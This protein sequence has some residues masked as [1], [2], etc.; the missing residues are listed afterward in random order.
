MIKTVKTTY[1]NA[2]RT[3]STRQIASKLPLNKTDLSPRLSNTSNQLLDSNN[4]R[5]SI[6]PNQELDTRDKK[7]VLAQM[8]Q[9]ISTQHSAITSKPKEPPIVLRNINNFLFATLSSHFITA[10]LLK[11]SDLNSIRIQNYVKSYF[12]ATE[13]NS[14]P[15]QFT[16]DNQDVSFMYEN[17]LLIKNFYLFGVCDGH[18]KNGKL[19]ADAVS[20]LFP[21]NL[22]YLIIDNNLIKRNENL[23]EIVISLFKMEE[24]SEVKD[25]NLLKYFFMKLDIDFD[26]ISFVKQALHLIRNEIVEAI[27]RTNEDC[28]TRK[29][30]DA[31]L[32]GCTLCS[33]FIYGKMLYAANVGDSRAVL[34]THIYDKNRWIT[35]ELTFD[36]KPDNIMEAK[37]IALSGGRIAQT[38][39]EIGI[40]GGPFRVWLK[41]SDSTTPGLAISR[42]IGDYQAKTIGVTYEPSIYEYQLDK[43]DKIIIIATDGLWE[44]MKNEQ[45]I[46]ICGAFYENKKRAEDASYQLIQKAKEDKIKRNKPYDDITCVVIFL[47]VKD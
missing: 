11:K 3:S 9:Q 16:S 36:H 44:N 24:K 17:F 1:P 4:K 47:D 13:K 25:I 40:E 34:G 35:K 20:I 18:G 12:S 38:K 45:A 2:T 46:A 33:I 7:S 19:I 43:N 8:Q 27:A 14:H 5:D 41:N 23:N 26:R 10:P 29:K 39:N 42:T 6:V 15:T 37:R 22:L 31:E 21:S 32:S 30:I 28:K